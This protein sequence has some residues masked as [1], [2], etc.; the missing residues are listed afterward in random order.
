MSDLYTQALA[1]IEDTIEWWEFTIQT[2]RFKID[3]SR[4]ELNAW[5]A[6]KAVL[7]RHEPIDRGYMRDGESILVCRSCGY[8]CHSSSGLNCDSPDGE[9]PCREADLIINA[10][11][12]TTTTA[13]ESA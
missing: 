9:F 2:P 11:L 3:E 8:M 1:K 4:Q 6:L 7:E 12:G 5:I 10:V 13:K